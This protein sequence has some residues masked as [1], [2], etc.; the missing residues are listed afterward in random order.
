MVGRI[1][2][3]LQRRE[4]ERDSMALFLRRLTTIE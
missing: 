1:Q 2:Q 3:E 4:Q